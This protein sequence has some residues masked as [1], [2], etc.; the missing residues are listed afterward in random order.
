[1]SSPS[2]YLIIDAQGKEHPLDLVDIEKNEF[3][4]R[5]PPLRNLLLCEEIGHAPHEKPPHIGIMR[6]LEI[7]DYERASDVGHLRFYPKGALMKELLEDWAIQ[8]ADEIGSIRV[9]TPIMYRADERDIQEQASRF[10]S[11]DYKVQVG[12][13]KLFLR[14]AGDFG[15]FRMLKRAQVSVKQLPIRIF[16]LSP[17][18]RLEKRG[19]CVGMRRQR[20]FT[21]PDIH[22]F[23]R[24]MEQAL[25]EFRRLSVNYARLLRGLDLE[26]VHVFRSTEDFY[27]EHRQFLSDLTRELGMI[28]L[29]RLLAWRTHYWTMK[30]EFQFIDSTGRN[31]QLATAQVDVEDSELYGL[32]YLNEQGKGKGYIIVHSSMGSIERCLCAI[33]ETAAKKMRMGALP[34]IPT[35]IAPVQVRIIPV[36]DRHTGY[37]LSIADRLRSKRVRADVDDRRKTVEWKIRASGKNWIPY[38]GVV[39]EKEERTK[40]ISVTIRG[41]STPKKGHIESMG[42]ERL[43]DMVLGE[44]ANMPF[45]PLGLSVRL[46]QS[47]S[48][49]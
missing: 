11:R 28:S 29:V 41:L 16:E 30:N 25:E 39:G 46:S 33:L 49:V 21:M 26:F 24:D 20:A 44:T 18:F 8:I 9:E 35:W 12:K 45:R 48:F 42:V 6:R 19:E 38:V 13:K 37:A 2:E 15:V 5:S 22:S 47:I 32:T 14:F 23:C 4:R 10:E 3:V 7:A 40:T 43:A 27:Q 31:F 17:S 36:A 1:M 34:T